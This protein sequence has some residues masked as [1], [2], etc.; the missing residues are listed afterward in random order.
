MKQ[1]HNKIAAF[2]ILLVL[3]APVSLLAQK[4]KEEKADKAKK[5]AQQIIITRKGDKADKIVVEINGDNITVNGKSLEEYKKMDGDVNVRLN[6]L[7]DIESL[8]FM[9]T[10]KEGAWTFNGDA[11]GLSYFNETSNHAML[12][13]VTEK[14][15]EGARVQ[16]ITKESAAEKM[17]LK[18]GD[19]IT[20]ID[21]K[22]VES[23]DDLSATIK[24]HKPGEKVTVTFLRDKKEQKATGELTKWK[25]INAFG[26]TTPFQ[27]MDLGEMRLN[28]LMPDMKTFPRMGG[29]GWSWSGG[30]P[31]LGLSVQDTDDGKGVKVIEVDEESN[32][33]KAGIKEDDIIT[34]ID[35]KQVNGVDE[36]SKIIR[37]KKENPVVRFQLTRNG[38]SQNIE[39]KMPRKI[40]TADL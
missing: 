2:V 30:S 7:K 16:E 33:A 9:R 26:T 18:K 34:H 12:G 23:P 15:D 10:P 31:K 4:E 40:K 11:D 20:K 19:I 39:V 32:A 1:M 36:V 37:E 22:K 29:Q 25:G 17:G 21:D 27:K 14:T 8:T 28:N 35:D 24:E 38:K 13:V 3:L 6:K 5:D